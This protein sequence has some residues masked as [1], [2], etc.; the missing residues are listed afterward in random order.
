[1]S[2]NFSDTQ[3]YN[4]MIEVFKITHEIYD[5][6]VSLK[7]VYHPNSNTR[8]N[9]YKLL[10]LSCI[11]QG[12]KRHQHGLLLRNAVHAGIVSKRLNI[13]PNFFSPSDSQPH[14]SRFS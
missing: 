11:R 5:P 4:C 9:N 12:Q 13:S 3:Q 6:D 14:H 1:M 7:L 8:G 10:E 2:P